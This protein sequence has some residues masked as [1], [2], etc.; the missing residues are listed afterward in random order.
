MRLQ[1]LTLYMTLYTL[2]TLYTLNDLFPTLPIMSLW[3]CMIAR[4]DPLNSMVR[5]DL[6]LRERPQD[7][8]AGH[9]YALQQVVEVCAEPLVRG[10]R[11]APALDC[12]RH[13]LVGMCDCKT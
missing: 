7:W 4:P 10:S 5:A 3:E 8:G 9:P 13:V 2:L 6:Y 11:S 1:D 12:T